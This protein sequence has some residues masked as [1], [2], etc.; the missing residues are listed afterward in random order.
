MLIIRSKSWRWFLSELVHF[1]SIWKH[2]KVQHFQGKH[3]Q[4]NI[5]CWWWYHHFSEEIQTQ[6]YRSLEALIVSGYGPPAGIWSTDWMVNVVFILFGKAHW[7]ISYHYHLFLY[8]LK[9]SENQKFSNVFRGCRKR[10]VPWNELR[11]ICN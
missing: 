11:S 9:S 3:K 2:S 5:S 1:F 8:P 10:P 4:F 7:P 6:Q